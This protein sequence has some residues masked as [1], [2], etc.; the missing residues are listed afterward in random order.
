MTGLGLEIEHRNSGKVSTSNITF[1]IKIHL[2]YICDIF[3]LLYQL[4]ENLFVGNY[5]SKIVKLCMQLMHVGQHLHPAQDRES[6]L[7]C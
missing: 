1:H 7:C 3:C 2:R 5:L 4:V 6:F